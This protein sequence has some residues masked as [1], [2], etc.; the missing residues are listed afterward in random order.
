MCN[1]FTKLVAGTIASAP[2]KNTTEIVIVLIH[3]KPI[4]TSACVV[5]WRFLADG[6]TL[7]F[8]VIFCF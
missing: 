2:K 5:V 6:E 4:F 3:W 1:H 7:H 8:V